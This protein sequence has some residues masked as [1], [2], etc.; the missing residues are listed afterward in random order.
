MKI[1]SKQTGL[2][3]MEYNIPLN[4]DNLVPAKTEYLDG[5]TIIVPFK[6]DKQM[7]KDLPDLIHEA[8]D[9]N[10]CGLIDL[11]FA[12]FDLWLDFYK[13]VPTYKLSVMSYPLKLSEQEQ[14]DLIQEL[15]NDDN[16]WSDTF[17]II[18]HFYSNPNWE[19][20]SVPEFY[21]VELEQAEV[22]KLNAYISEHLLL[23]IDLFTTV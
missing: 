22:D 7:L 9:V 2:R 21:D 8:G 5:F 15:G 4:I 1:I 16:C 14:K 17:Y 12:K 18:E 13:E 6:Q 3:G 11:N 19:E 20:M 10:Y 23:D